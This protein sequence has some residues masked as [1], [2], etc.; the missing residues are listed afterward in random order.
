M[1][2]L[3]EFGLLAGAVVG[4]VAAVDWWLQGKAPSRTSR[5]ERNE[6]AMMQWDD[7][8][9]GNM[10]DARNHRRRR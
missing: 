5:R 6:Q 3:M 8:S 7:L 4:L 9:N 10:S 2:E 1:L